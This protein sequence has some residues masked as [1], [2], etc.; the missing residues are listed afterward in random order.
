MF[1]DIVE[2]T[3][4]CSSLET[5]LVVRLLDDLYSIFDAIAKKRG[6]YKVETIGDS[7]MTVTGCVD[8]ESIYPATLRMIDFANDVLVAV[9]SFRPSY[10]GPEIVIEVRIGI[11]SGPVIAGLLLCFLQPYGH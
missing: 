4:I 8:N 5:L 1:T 10:L 2:Y 9:R 3:S 7:Y 11:H 6:V